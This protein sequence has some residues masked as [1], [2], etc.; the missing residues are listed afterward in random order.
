M[1]VQWLSL[2]APNARR[3]P[4]FVPWSGNWIPHA[5]AQSLHATTKDPARLQGRTKIP[6]ATTKTRDVEVQK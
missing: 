4:R 2:H 6:R 1:V 5:T 3:G